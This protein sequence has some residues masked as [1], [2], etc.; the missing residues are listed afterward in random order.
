[1][2]VG[3]DEMLPFAALDKEGRTAHSFECAYRRV[4]T[5]RNNLRGAFV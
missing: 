2:P 3:V 1:M 5:T 4:D